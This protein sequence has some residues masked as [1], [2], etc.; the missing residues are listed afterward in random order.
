MSVYIPD[1]SWWCIPGAKIGKLYE[2]KMCSSHK[3]QAGG[4]SS[5]MHVLVQIFILCADLVGVVIL[6]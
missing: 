2:R 1:C 5:T 4:D 3:D 6:D